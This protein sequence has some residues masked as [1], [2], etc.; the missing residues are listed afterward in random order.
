M[1]SSQLLIVKYQSA[2]TVYWVFLVVNMFVSEMFQAGL[3]VVLIKHYIQSITWLST[4]DFTEPTVFGLTYVWLCKYVC[5]NND[6]SLVNVNIDHM[7]LL[8]FILDNGH[9]L[10]QQFASPFFS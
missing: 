4:S 7:C 1:A 3:D 10:I 9:L 8:Y 2:H 6:L 5:K